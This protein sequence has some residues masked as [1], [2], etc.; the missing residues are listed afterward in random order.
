MRKYTEQEVYSLQNDNHRI[1]EKSLSIIVKESKKRKGAGY[2][3]PYEKWCLNQ[4]RLYQEIG[5]YSQEEL[6]SIKTEEEKTPIMS[7]RNMFGF[8]AL[9][10]CTQEIY[11]GFEKILCDDDEIG[12]WRYYKRKS[13]KKKRPCLIYIHGGAWIAGSVFAV[14][15]QCRLIAQKADAVVF[16]LDYTLAPEAKY[17]T[18]INSCYQAV[19]HI[20]DHAREYGI[21][22]EQ[23]MIAGDSAGGNLAAALT[24][25]ARDEGKNLFFLQYLLYPGVC[26][27]NTVNKLEEY[28]WSIDAYDIA[29]E[30]KEMILPQLVMGTG[31]SPIDELTANSY[32]KNAEDSF[33]PYVSPV[34]AENLKDLPNTVIATADFDGLR[35]Q[36]ELYASKLQEAGNQVEI[37]RYAG[38]FHAF[39]DRLGYVPQAEAVCQDIAMRLK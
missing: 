37:V 22:P 14:E 1:Q 27:K 24:L 8:P 12:L 18:T 6:E 9:N 21:D 17:P 33:H 3:D 31:E 13:I 35:L 32:L 39:F 7:I 10:L 16:N 34:L 5:E 36:G 23:V 30:E 38:T 15:N 4:E 25:K 29:E 2:I 28:H 26:V 20:K 19:C 11:S